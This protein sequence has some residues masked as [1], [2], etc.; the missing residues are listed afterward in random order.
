MY[1]L[2]SE[3]VS[4]FFLLLM[5]A[6]TSESE[7]K[8]DIFFSFLLFTGGSFYKLSKF[9][10]FLFSLSS[11]SFFLYLLLAITVSDPESDSESV[12]IV[13]FLFLLVL[14]FMLLSSNS[15]SWSVS[16]LSLHLLFMPGIE[17][18]NGWFYYLFLLHG[19]RLE[20]LFWFIFRYNIL[21]PIWLGLRPQ[22][23]IL[24][25]LPTPHKF[26]HHFRQF[27]ATLVC[28]HFL[29]I[30]CFASTPKKVTFRHSEMITQWLCSTNRSLHTLPN[31]T[32]YL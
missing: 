2:F 13:I 20:S 7:F 22:T 19:L 31:T 24:V 12:T 17:V 27:R 6:S 11:F 5:W 21:K 28:S 16:F 14:T 9:T 8:S 25:P 32:T 30:I 15:V 4:N 29:T 26:S 1:R 18:K 3:S 23:G 10:P